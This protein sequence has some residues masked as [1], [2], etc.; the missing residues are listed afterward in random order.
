MVQAHYR[1]KLVVLGSM[2]RKLETS[3]E[4]LLQK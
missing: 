2:V 1:D 4:I 3:D